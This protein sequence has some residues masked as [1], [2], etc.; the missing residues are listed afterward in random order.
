MKSM[1]GKAAASAFLLGM[2]GCLIWYCIF[3]NRIFA[4]DVEF[5]KSRG[6]AELFSES[7]LLRG[8]LAYYVD[9]DSSSAV[10]FYREAIVRQPLLIDAWLALAKAEMV[11]GENDVA[12]KTISVLS[13]LISHVSTWKWQELLLA[14]DMRDED[15]FAES[16]NFILSRLPHRAE[17]S[18]YLAVDFWGSWND[19][20]PHVAPESSLAFLNQLKKAKEADVAMELWR[21]MEQG[22]E[23]PDKDETL[24]FCN[25]L[26]NNGKLV[27]AKEIWR[28]WKGDSIMGVYDGGFEYEPLNTAFGWR[29]KKQND[30]IVERSLETPYSGNYCLQLHFIGGSNVAF[31]HVTQIVPV[32]PGGSYRVK[33]AQRSRHL[34]TDQGVFVA[35]TGHLC[36]GLQAQSSPI[37]GTNS[38]EEAQFEF[39]A[40]E[41]CE[42]VAL[43]VMRKE[44]LKFDSKISGDYWIDSVDLEAV[45]MN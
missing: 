23:P 36:K 16:L 24:R 3:T 11:R 14:Y 27:F 15:Y 33:F 1:L 34:T 6:S 26:L 8:N 38:W 41:N 40:P 20:L 13:P 31:N 12:D 29:W 17:E 19:V 22:S 30:V 21:K 18:C 44:S 32:N 25:F 2:V 10:E 42:A 43:R 5:I 39:Q 45:G 37:I 9:L 7:W 28:R 4:K 35:V